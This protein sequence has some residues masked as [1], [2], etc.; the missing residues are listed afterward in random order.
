MV[1]APITGTRRSDP[2][3][4]VAVA[5]G[6]PLNTPFLSI[7]KL[8][9]LD[10][11]DADSLPGLGNGKTTDSD[12]IEAGARLETKQLRD[13]L[14]GFQERL[15][16][17]K[18]QALLV[19]LQAMDTGGKD[20]VIERVF[21]GVNPQGVRVAHFDKPSTLELSHDYLWRA[22][23]QAPRRGEICIFNRS[24][25]EDVLIVRVQNLVPKSTWEK[26]YEHIRN[27]EQM[28]ADEGTVV[29]KI[30][31]LI[32][33]DEQKKRLQARLDDTEK[34]WK[35]DPNDL[36][37]RAAWDDY[38]LAY[39]DAIR[40]TDRKSAPWHIIPANRKWY[41]DWAVMHLIVQTL[42][43]MNPRVPTSTVD[44]R[45]IVIK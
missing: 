29:L 10:Q 4:F 30:C 25:Y 11:L 1:Y 43:Q 40:E 23:L 35:F 18:Q 24:H 33:K 6:S 3:V 16:A 17:Q 12:A 2:L 5:W 19:V 27:F 9:S 37:Q 44:A 21:S 39:A 13:E 31:L 20:A 38:M 26:R 22:H 41:R 28:L 42:K 34:L 7:G 32:S 36:V 45:S 8:R 14:V 15:Y